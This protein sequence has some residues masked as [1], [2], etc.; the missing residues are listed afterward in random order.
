MASYLTPSTMSVIKK[1]PCNEGSAC[2]CS[3]NNYS[4]DGCIF[5]A[6]STSSQV[7]VA[8][9]AATARALSDGCQPVDFAGWGAPTLN[10]DAAPRRER[11]NGASSRSQQQS[12]AQPLLKVPPGHDFGPSRLL[13][14]PE[15]CGFCQDASA[16]DF[17]G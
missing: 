11:S 17:F 5:L 4:L 8:T 15:Y 9:L 7:D 10:T 14:V 12:R 2:L 16:K 3:S 13:L 1:T 6:A